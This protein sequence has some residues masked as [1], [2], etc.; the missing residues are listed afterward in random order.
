MRSERKL[1]E[2]MPV[3]FQ[4]KTSLAKVGQ[5]VARGKYRDRK[6]RQLVPLRRE[7][8]MT[9]T[10]WGRQGVHLRDISGRRCHVESNEW[11]GTDNAGAEDTDEHITS[12]H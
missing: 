10:G 11:I 2:V 6:G 5:G 9:G 12:I 3:Q 8:R 7:E 4:I 1:Y